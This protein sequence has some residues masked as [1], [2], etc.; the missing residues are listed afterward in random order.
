MSSN[1]ATIRLVVASPQLKRTRGLISCLLALGTELSCERRRTGRKGRPAAKKAVPACVLG[2][3][4][5]IYRNR[6][7]PSH[8]AEMHARHLRWWWWPLDRSASYKVQQ[9]E[10]SFYICKDR[11]SDCKAYCSAAECIVSHIVILS[12]HLQQQRGLLKKTRTN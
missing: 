8:D 4:W 6:T 10:P 12:W 2:G 7:K 3:I 9:L 11:A 1:S 5:G